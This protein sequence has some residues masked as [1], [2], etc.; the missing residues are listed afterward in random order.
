MAWFRYKCEEHGE[1]KLSLE[2]REK[3]ALC[4]T[5]KRESNGIIKLGSISVVE[6]LDNG[7]MARA[8][9]RL[10]NIEDI[11]EE[12]SRKHEENQNEGLPDDED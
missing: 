7:A 4:P 10:H 2:E 5:C 9:E 3:T 6:R 12:R 11:M 8:V 1:F